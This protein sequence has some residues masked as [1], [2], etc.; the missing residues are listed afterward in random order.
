MREC[1]LKPKLSNC[2]YN[3]KNVTPHAGVWIETISF[4]IM[5]AIFAVTPHAG[6][7]IETVSHVS[8]DRSLKVTPHAGVWIETQLDKSFY[9][10]G[11]SHSPC[12][13]VD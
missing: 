11:I 12:G 4:G 6:V 9:I 5:L 7:W 1:G 8:I 10:F 13:S 3:F 2:I